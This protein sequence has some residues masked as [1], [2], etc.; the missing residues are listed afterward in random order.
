MEIFRVPKREVQARIL[1]D[2]GRTVDC[3]IYTALTSPEGGPQ[4][5]VDRLNDPDEEFLPVHAGEERFLLNRSG[6]VTV[7]LAG[8][9]ETIEGA[10]SE[11]G[12]RIPVRLSLTGGIGLLGE[13][14]VVMPPERSRALDY[15]NAAP[16]F[17]PVLGEDRVTLVQRN[18]IVSVLSDG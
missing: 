8:D 5:V 7:E 13:F 4:R 6:I 2:D 15:L 11:A 1:L 18:Y 9:Q 16:R 17:L 14:H 12:K 10:D 3:T